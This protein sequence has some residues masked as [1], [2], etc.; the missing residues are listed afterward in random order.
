MS[1]GVIF[2]RTSLALPDLVVGTNPLGSDFWLP[3]DGFNEPEFSQRT[4]YADPAPGLHGQLATQSATDVGSFA[5][6]IYT[7]AADEAALKANKRALE[8]AVRQFRYTLGLTIVGPT[9]SYQAL[10]GQVSWGEVDSGMVRQLMA[11]AVVTVPVQPL[12]V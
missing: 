5:A 2:S 3:E 12:E 4:T 8:A 11:R 7:Q 1:R 10:A 6:L 9:D